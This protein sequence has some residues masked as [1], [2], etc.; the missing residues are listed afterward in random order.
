[1]DPNA[2]LEQQRRIIARMHALS[3]AEN[4]SADDMAELGA[5]LAELAEALDEWLTRGGFTPSA[6]SVRR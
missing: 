1:M 2:N 4:M 3:S 6:W 5:E